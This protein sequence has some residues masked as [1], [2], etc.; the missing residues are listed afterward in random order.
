MNDQTYPAT[1][2]MQLQGRALRVLAAISEISE[3]FQE[4]LSRTLKPLRLSP[5]QYQALRIIRKAGQDGLPTLSLQSQ[6]THRVLDVTRLLDR[7]EAAGHVRRS[8]SPKDRRVVLVQ[9]TDS[10]EGLLESL[11]EPFAELHLRT[12]SPLAAAELGQLE[13]LLERLH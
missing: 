3:R 1:Q 5:L 13:M 9:L 11:D 2:Q 6:I 7:L 4:E 12:L 8:R 10:G